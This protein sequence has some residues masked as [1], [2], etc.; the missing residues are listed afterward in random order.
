MA[1]IED[2]ID[3]LY[4]LPLKEFT[5]ARNTLAKEV[6]GADSTRVRTLQKPNAAA[7]AVNQ[8][9]WRQRP[10]Y[11]QLV[12]A[13]ERLRTAHRAL[14]AGKA[15][16]LHGVEAAHRDRIRGATQQIRELLAEA[17]ESPSPQTMTAVA[18]T[19]EALPP[20]DEQPG[21]L[22]K[23]LKRIGFE[24]LAGV[25]PR[26]GPPAPRKLALVKGTQKAH[27]PPPKTPAKPELSPAKKREIDEIEKRL[28]AMQVE[29][30]QLHA[31]VER[32]RRELQRAENAHARVEQ[33]LAEAKE[34]VRQLR[35][36]LASREKAHTSVV[37][38]E[39]TLEHRLQKLTEPR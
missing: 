25:P 31:D 19:L 1:S 17:G 29:K 39:E 14:V 28:G 5:P 32:A 27:E 20:V 37:T 16:D 34:K 7:W 13:A 22:T 9:Y 33:E 6:R 30:R 10:T 12:H 2:E 21:R 15:V 26:S 35:A 4:Q 3:R 11:D 36:D 23:P 38:E 24:A 18:E 8:L